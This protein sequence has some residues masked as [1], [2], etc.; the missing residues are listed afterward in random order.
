[1]HS[2]ASFVTTY[3]NPDATPRTVRVAV[4]PGTALSFGLTLT[5]V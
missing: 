1:M 4:N 2:G 5:A 3:A